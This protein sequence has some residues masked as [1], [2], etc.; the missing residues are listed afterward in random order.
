MT[1]RKAI[2][3][4]RRIKSCIYCYSHKLKCSRTTP[5][6]TCVTNGKETEC[7]YWT[8]QTPVG[9]AVTGKKV[10]I[11]GQRL[12]LNWQLPQDDAYSGKFFYP[13]FTPSMNNHVVNTK[14]KTKLI[15]NTSFTRNC[16]T[17]FDKTLS[18]SVDIQTIVGYILKNKSTLESK[19][20]N[21]FLNI[22]P[23]VPVIDRTDV[24]RRIDA[25]FGNIDRQE[26][27]NPL[28]AMLL[29]SILFCSVY[30]SVSSCE[31]SDLGE[32]KQYYIFFRYLLD[33][34]RFPFVPYIE[35]LQSYVIVNFVMDPNMREAV[36][37]SAM[38][39]RMAQQL[40]LHKIS[41]TP[42]VS[43]DYRLYLFHFILFLDG[44][45]SVAS[46]FRFSAPKDIF[47][48]VPIPRSPAKQGV[49]HPTPVDFTICRF[50]M[51]YL[52]QQIMELTAKKSISRT[53]NDYVE[54]KIGLLYR[55]VGKIEGRLKHAFPD[56][57]AYFS[58]SLYIFLH[59]LHLRFFALEALQVYAGGLDGKELSNATP[60]K[61]KDI[62]WILDKEMPLRDEVVPLTLL[63]LLNTMERLVQHD[64]NGLDWYTR[65]S[66]VMQYLFV[67]LRDLYQNPEKEYPLSSFVEPLYGSISF[68][69]KEIITCHPLLFKYKLIDELMKVLE[70]RLAPL[71]NNNELYK[72]VL[73]NMVKEKVWLHNNIVITENSDAH[74]QLN[75]C[76]LFLLG[77]ALQETQSSGVEDYITDLESTFWGADAEKI[78][79]DWLTDFS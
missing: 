11:A 69:I 19:L 15:S 49:Q 55:D 77:N 50:R 60:S 76:R 75:Q 10:D 63:L 4:N 74:L 71:W 26:N 31:L 34:T 54:E 5:C 2:T 72:F 79:I 29:V 78:M 45:S 33:V 20:E 40:D 27:I 70:V 8:G 6:A 51:N 36:G 39:V 57:A 14:P 52:F 44:S 53:E 37:Y 47:K 12:S 24:E 35:T 16:I 1:K 41:V 62:S 56:R 25:L 65:G 64:C 66:T 73:V 30:G 7:K 23:I 48:L 38:L 61:S 9:C 28:D 18:A 46:G 17:E 68:D 59:R 67:I 43:T 22:H 3:R 21:Y 42:E 58:S 32:V 13:F